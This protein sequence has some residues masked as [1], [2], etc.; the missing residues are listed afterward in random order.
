MLLADPSECG[1]CRTVTSEETGLSNTPDRVGPILPLRAAIPYD[2]PGR[3]LPARHPAGRATSRAG[4][5]TVPAMSRVPPPGALAHEPDPP[6]PIHGDR[7][8]RLGRGGRP[9]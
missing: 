8:P 6:R 2:G 4:S 9:T 3:L 5:P 7:R 1:R